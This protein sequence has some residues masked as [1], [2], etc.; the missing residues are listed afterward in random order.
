[1]NLAVNLRRILKRRDLTVARLAR[2]T[3]IP[4]TTLANWLNGS[5]PRKLNQ[6]K[7][8]ADFL[9]I[10]IDELC[11]SAKPTGM[12]K[13]LNQHYDEEVLEGLFEVVLRR[14]SGGSP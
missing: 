8:V 10:S 2:A 11:Y 13:G 3:K 1:M 9:E 7:S 6:V 5:P 14:Y 12:S 4:K